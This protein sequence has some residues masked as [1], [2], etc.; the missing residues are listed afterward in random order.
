[1]S[2]LASTMRRSAA[3]L[4]LKSGISTS[5]EVS[6][7]RRRISEMH[8]AKTSAPPFGKSSRSTLVITT[9]FSP[10]CATAAARRRGSLLS[11][12]C[13]VPCATAQYAQFRVHRVELEVAHH[14]LERE[15]V[16]TAGRLHLQPGGL[17]SGLG[18]GR[19]LGRLD[20]NKGGGHGK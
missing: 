5:T 4:P 12:G 10:I 14:V 20:L 15:I 7:S 11:S 17:A 9:C 8:A 16:G 19:W 2:G 1:M 18:C 13:G 3:G 6:G